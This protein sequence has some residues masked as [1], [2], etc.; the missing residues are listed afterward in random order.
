MSFRKL[1]AWSLA[2]A[3]VAFAP[4]GALGQAFTTPTVITGTDSTGSPIYSPV[5]TGTAASGPMPVSGTSATSV[6][7]A[8][9]IGTS[10]A[11]VIAAGTAKIYLMLHNPSAAGGNTVY[12]REGSAAAVATAG[13]LSIAPGQY[14]T[15]ENSLVDGGAWNCIATGASTPFTYGAK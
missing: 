8:A 5:G 7:Q 15:M 11:Q 6:F 12:C 14:V 4:S 1:V 2:L 9:T 3:A 10:S 13:N